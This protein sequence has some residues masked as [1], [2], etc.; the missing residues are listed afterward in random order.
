MPVS[1]RSVEECKSVWL[2]ISISAGLMSRIPVLTNIVCFCDPV[3]YAYI[4]EIK[5]KTK[6]NSVK[7]F[8]NL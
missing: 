7:K 8:V 1:V 6:Q 3:H 5:Q 2:Y 4:R